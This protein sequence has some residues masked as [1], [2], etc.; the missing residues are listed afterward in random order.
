MEWY[1]ILTLVLAVVTT[2]TSLFIAYKAR[3]IKNIKTLTDK[4]W[5]EE[6]IEAIADMFNIGVD[7]V[8]AL[9]KIFGFNLNMPGDV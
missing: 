4:E 2:L 3:I 6:D 7:V 9:L 8:K 5:N 1:Y